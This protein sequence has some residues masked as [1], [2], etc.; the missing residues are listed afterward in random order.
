MKV[1]INREPVV[2]PWGGGNRF[3][4]QF[5]ETLQSRGHEV[6][7]RLQPKIDVLFCVDPR[8]SPWGDNFIDL[9]EY[10]QRYEVP[11]HARIGDV[12][13]HGKPILLD[14]F[15]VFLKDVDKVI[16]PSR[17]AK[18][19]LQR[20]LENVS[21]ATCMNWH[22]I[23]NGPLPDFYMNRRSNNQL[24]NSKV[25]VVTHHWSDNALKGF[26][27]YKLLESLPNV[28]FTYIGR[29]PRDFSPKNFAGCLSVDDLRIEIPRHDIYISASKW[30]AGANH[31]LEG[32]ACGLPM[33]YSKEGGSIVEYCEDYGY[34]FDNPEQIKICLDM[35]LNQYESCHSSVMT[36]TRTTDDVVADYVNLLS[37]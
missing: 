2:G 28:Q 8:P 5:I 27:T 6:V 7:H 17:W 10:K 23:E 19:Y 35:L 21:Y 20:V 22:V 26:E 12:G 14:I 31:V 9:I 15:R 25:K 18:E 3:V 37:L 4:T 1:Y 36:Y 13:T 11:L 33:I 30:E 29:K 24:L 16:F 34:G 32:L